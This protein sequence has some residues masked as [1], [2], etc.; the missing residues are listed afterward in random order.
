MLLF[1]PVAGAGTSSRWPRLQPASGGCC[2]APGAPRPRSIL[3][4]AGSVRAAAL[5]EVLDA[6]AELTGRGYIDELT[7]PHGN[8]V[9]DI[10]AL[11]GRRPR[12][13]ECSGG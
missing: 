13:E 2:S 6:A 3:A 10:D 1:D 9:I 7:C 11:L 12:R 4:M 8:Q 5:C